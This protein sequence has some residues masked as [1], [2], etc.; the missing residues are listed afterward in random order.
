M[1]DTDRNRES[2]E[3]VGT[4]ERSGAQSGFQFDCKFCEKTLGAAT[5]KAVK[6]W[7][8]SH[9][10]ANHYSDL[11]K[12]FARKIG[13]DGCRNDCGYVFPVEVEAVAGFDCPECGHDHFQS[14][15]RRYL[16]W[17]I[18]ESE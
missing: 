14:F 10:E 7:G 4:V 16:Y 2:D 18:E 1:T 12:V 6:S 8:T 9:L 3:Y 11:R 17:E 15:V 5:A 13:G